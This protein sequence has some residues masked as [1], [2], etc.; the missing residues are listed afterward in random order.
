MKRNVIEAAVT[1][2]T[3]VF[4]VRSRHGA[5]IFTEEQIL[6]RGYNHKFL[7][8]KNCSVHAEVAA[9]AN[10]KKKLSMLPNGTEICCL[11][12][13]INKKGNLTNSMPCA[14]CRRELRKHGINTVYYSVKGGE[15]CQMI[16]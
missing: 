12:V 7:G 16:L 2:A 9:I 5:V 8:M 13:R 1:L 3:N 14:N 15:I 11:V 4:N 10:A 6:G